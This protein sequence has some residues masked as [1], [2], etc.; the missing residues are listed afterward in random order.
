MT[1]AKYTFEEVVP[2]SSPMA[3][4]DNIEHWDENSL[5][6][7]VTLSEKSPFAS[8]EGVPT[9]I[10]IEYMAQ[11]IA[12]F[13]GVKSRQQQGDVKIGLLLGSRRYSCNRELFPL[14]TLIV[15]NVEKVIGSDNGLFVFECSIS[16]PNN[17][18]ANANLNVFE[19]EDTDSFLQGKN[20]D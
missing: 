4:L 1:V 5:S 17:L 15:V 12:A 6:A 9:W 14:N 8:A 2:H 16:G 20:N 3:L 13:S 7:S 18:L 11:A 19:P 10:G